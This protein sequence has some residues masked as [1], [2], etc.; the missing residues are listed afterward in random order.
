MSATSAYDETAAQVRRPPGT[1]GRDDRDLV[2]MATPRRHH[3]QR[4]V[5]STEPTAVTPD[6]TQELTSVIRTTVVDSSGGDGPPT[7]PT[8]TGISFRG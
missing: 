6:R 4:H 3:R 7:H 5:T 8:A 1:A 2:R